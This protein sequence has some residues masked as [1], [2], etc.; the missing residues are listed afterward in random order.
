MKASEQIRRE[1]TSTK[2]AR[3][4]PPDVHTRASIL[5]FFEN[6]I[7]GWLTLSILFGMLN[8][9]Q[10]QPEDQISLFLMN[11]LML[12]MFAWCTYRA[13]RVWARPRSAKKDNAML[14]WDQSGPLWLALSDSPPDGESLIQFNSNTPDIN[15]RQRLFG[16][17]SY[18]LSRGRVL[19]NV[20]NKDIPRINAIRDYR[21]SLELDDHTELK[22]QT[23]IMLATLV[24]TEQLREAFT[25]LSNHLTGVAQPS[26]AASAQY[27][28]VEQTQP[29]SLI[30]APDP[31][32]N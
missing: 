16:C 26:T 23:R 12:G 4:V 25:R 20:R 17:A 29:I 24:E 30:Q 8:F 13:Y 10:F 5:S 32:G 1:M 14:E 9:S 18:N 11:I 28:D 3:V 6:A 27:D 22:F 19:K 15:W 21:Q 31:P 2:G 7:L